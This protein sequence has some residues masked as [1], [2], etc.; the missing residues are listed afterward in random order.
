MSISVGGNPKDKRK[1]LKW[2][3]CLEWEDDVAENGSKK[4]TCYGRW[5]QVCPWCGSDLEDV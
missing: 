1:P 4:Y 3:S 2:C 5:G